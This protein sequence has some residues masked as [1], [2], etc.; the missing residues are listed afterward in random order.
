M[1]TIYQVI[2]VVFWFY[3]SITFAS[4]VVYMHAN[5]SWSQILHINYLG[6]DTATQRRVLQLYIVMRNPFVGWIPF[7]ICA[8][9]R[10]N[11]DVNFWSKTVWSWTNGNMGKATC[12]QCP[13]NMLLDNSER[14]LAHQLS[15][16]P[17]SASGS[18]ATDS[19]FIQWIMPMIFRL[20]THKLCP[21]VTRFLER[22]GKVTR[23][24]I[25]SI[26]QSMMLSWMECVLYNGW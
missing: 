10:Y 12:Q 9:S 8:I 2:Q 22:H 16:Y 24:L 17:W 5:W 3:L 18:L 20:W 21:L 15:F 14:I 6:I 26:Q 19:E 23:G 1:I 11:S 4:V 7:L 13:N 25:W